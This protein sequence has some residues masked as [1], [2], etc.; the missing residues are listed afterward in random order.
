MKAGLRKLPIFRQMAAGQKEPT[1]RID[2]WDDREKYQEDL[3]VED[4]HNFQGVNAQMHFKVPVFS[5]LIHSP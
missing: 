4:E 1:S 2:S 5:G 3:Y